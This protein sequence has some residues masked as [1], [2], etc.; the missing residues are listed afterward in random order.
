MWYTMIS[1]NISHGMVTSTAYKNQEM[2]RYKKRWE[3]EVAKAMSERNLQVGQWEDQD[4][5]K[6]DIGHH[7]MFWNQYKITAYQLIRTDD[8]D[9]TYQALKS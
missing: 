5:W 6:S 3:Q 7:I 9:H 4:A 1:L 2:G 8:Y